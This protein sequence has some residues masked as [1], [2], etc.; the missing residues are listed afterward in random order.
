MPEWIHNRAEHISAKNP[1]MP[2][3]QA[4]AIATQQSHAVGKTPK[5]Y[6]T[7]E[8]RHVAKAKFSTPK[9][10]KKMANPGQLVSAKMAGVKLAVSKNWAFRLS[11]SGAEKAA[12]ERV[13]AFANRMYAKSTNQYKKVPHS[14]LEKGFTER[15]YK[16]LT[17][18]QRSADRVGGLYSSAGIGASTSGVV[19]KGASRDAMLV[20]PADKKISNPEMSEASKMASLEKSGTAW[21]RYVRIGGSEIDPKVA[22]LVRQAPKD[23]LR[24]LLS[25]PSHGPASERVKDIAKIELGFAERATKIASFARGLEKISW[26]DKIPGGLADN[27][28][29]DSFD[30]KALRDGM[31]VESEHARDPNTQ[32]EIS[33][34]HLTEDP[35]YYKKLRRME[36]EASDIRK[37]IGADRALQIVKGTRVDALNKKIREVALSAKRSIDPKTGKLPPVMQRGRVKNFIGDEVHKHFRSRVQV[38]RRLVR[39]RNAERNAMYKARNVERAQRATAPSTEVSNAPHAATSSAAA[40][41]ANKHLGHV[42]PVAAAAS[43][44]GAGLYGKHVHDRNESLGRKTASVEFLAE[45]ELCVAIVREM[46][47]T[48]GFRDSMRSIGQAMVEP[49]PGTKPWLLSADKAITRNASVGSKTVG[50]LRPRGAGQP[51]RSTQMSGG[52]VYNVAHQAAEYGL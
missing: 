10:D 13:S 48:A 17:P 36:K 18:S 46:Q 39:E 33:M 38:G 50:K 43:A 15:G 9:D 24:R 4:F 44:L 3:S 5:G 30:I 27:K 20:G 26:K 6:G 35:Q 11:S 41:K 32:R 14:F 37:A 42:V 25:H 45:R 52:K 29:P 51:V 7:A 16:E 34:D 28:T 8:G 21:S 2:K 1:S 47:K 22:R 49:I 23:R 31:K 12:P 40:P 19:R